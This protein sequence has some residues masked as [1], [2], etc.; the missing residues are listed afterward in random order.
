M[1]HKEK[2]LTFAPAGLLT[3]G[4]GACLIQWASDKKRNRASTT[5][6]VSAGTAALVVFNAGLSLFGRGV[7]EG[8]LYDLKEK[9][10][11]MDFYN[12]PRM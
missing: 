12:V 10:R 7:A 2:W 4:L 9:P 8:V 6:W 11:E 1:T 3:I 5:E